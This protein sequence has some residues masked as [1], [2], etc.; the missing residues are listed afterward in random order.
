MAA[1]G[2]KSAPGKPR[3]KG[4]E[5]VPGL[6][7]PNRSRDKVAKVF[8][9]NAR[10]VN[11]AERVKVVKNLSTVVDIPERQARP[12]TRLKEPEQQQEAWAS[13][14]LSGCWTSLTMPRCRPCSRPKAGRESAAGRNSFGSILSTPEGKPPFSAASRRSRIPDPRSSSDWRSSW[15]PEIE[16]PAQSG[17]R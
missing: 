2:A 4:V 9:T 8:G 11:Q 16:G 13:P 10:Y 7:L 1:G 5:K 15:I 6:S 3:D 14:A 12:L 17:S